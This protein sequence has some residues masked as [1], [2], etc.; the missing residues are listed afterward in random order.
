M[1]F[2]GS[3]LFLIIYIFFG[4]NL[5]S[6]QTEDVT[7][8][9]PLFEKL[10]NSEHKDKSTIYNLISEKY[11]DTNP[12][13]ALVYADSA[14][15]GANS[16]S[17]LQNIS[18]AFYNAG[19]ANYKLAQYEKSISNFL[20]VLTFEQSLENDTILGNIYF[21]L[22][23]TYNSL[24]NHELAINYFTKA[25]GYFEKLE[26]VDK[27]MLTYYSIGSAYHDEEDYEASLKN[28][29]IALNISKN[30]DEPGQ[31]A[32]LYNGLGILYFDLGSYE[33]ALGY[34]I[35][36]LNLYEKNEDN[37]G[38][39]NALNNIGI[40][41]NDWGKKEKSL[42]YYQKS[43]RIEEKSGDQLGVAGLYN[44]MGI[45]YSD[46]GQH[47]LANDYYEKSLEICQ[48][49]NDQIGICY[50]LNNLGE[51]YAAMG[52]Y[53]KAI[54]FLNKSLDIEFLHGSKKGVA[55]SYHAIGSVYL[56]MKNY[57][58][59]LAFNKKCFLVA[60]SLNLMQV[61]LISKKLYYDIH[62]SM[63]SYKEALRY[64]EEYEALKDSIYNNNFQGKM[65][66]LQV[67]YE[68][69]HKQ[70]D[71]EQRKLSKT[72][73]EKE[74]QVQ[75][76]YLILIFILLI[77]FG[78]LIYFEI[79][80]KNKT[81][82]KLFVSNKLLIEEKEKLSAALNNI[83]KYEQKYRNIIKY[84]T[85]G[86]LYIDRL[87]KIIEINEKMLNIIGLHDEKSIDEIN[88]FKYT[89][90]KTMGLS[91]DIETCIETR[92]VVY[93]EIHYVTKWGK[94]VFL[95]YYLT[96][97][98]EDGITTTHVI[99]N[100]EDI[101][102]SLEAANSRRESELKYRMLVENSLQAMLII[103]DAKMIFANQR[104]EELSQYSFKEL[105]GKGR[106]W[107]E[108]LIHPDDIKR[109]MKNVRDALS[110]KPV[111]PKQVYKIIRKD[112]KVRLMETISSIVDYQGK[113]AMLVV[114][115]DDTERK[116]AETRLIESEKQLLSAN[117]MK[118]KFFSIIA[119][120]LKNPFSSIVGFSNLL[121]EGYANFSEKQRKEFIKN[122][123]EASENTFKLLQ[124][125]L[126][127]SRTQTGNIEFEPDY[128]DVGKIVNENI[129][130]LNSWFMNKKITVKSII[131]ERTTA[132]ADEN[133]IKVVVRNLLSNALKFTNENGSIII[134]STTGDGEVE[135]C[136]EDDGVGLSEE[137]IEKLFRI[138]EHCKS[139]GTAKEEGTG[140]GLIL[141][142][143]FVTKNK[144][145][146]SVQSTVGKGSK[147]SFSIPLTGEPDNA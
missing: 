122:I 70:R 39:S 25:L 130:L 69:D 29:F 82:T 2:R 107:L 62:K 22:G 17:D 30:F 42:E 54:D 112:G 49:F 60:D 110:G 50:A 12:E 123:C 1:R 53:K 57:N 46:W 117:S 96:P 139:K 45:I 27:I 125:L 73:M 81:N 34:Y 121:Y 100:V 38:I 128:I 76:T 55:Q 136:F 97:I 88:C 52:Q 37:K 44:N 56:M 113:P 10:K 19:Q 74:K 95:K 75:R 103:Q 41:Y 4:I 21:S 63:K 48:R 99:A 109:S 91:E 135:V 65:T 120:D 145:K 8:L 116:N 143:E 140:L 31:M 13:L 146:I 142:K 86:I 7:I 61:I 59:A 89:P 28:Y 79:K 47:E 3:F 132:F 85:A 66:D 131:P 32:N 92:K 118:D 127:W 98:S 147:F 26:V 35:E 9:K 51:S 18:K 84:S 102:A 141:C 16:H 114:A 80:S 64:Y 5:C 23:Y 137:R 33:K 106:Q 40:V 15:Q 67:S 119:H 93:N 108:V 36:A 72:I 24:G 111:E 124:N 129:A 58:E 126:E 20:E 14:L 43:L 90:M 138:D 87:G 6:S 94:S 133:M 101:T 68:F 71:L 11:V 78:V 115:I 134:S 83:S 77:V 104:M 144:G 105:A